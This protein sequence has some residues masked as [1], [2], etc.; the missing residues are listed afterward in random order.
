MAV[1]TKCAVATDSMK[2]KNCCS[3]CNKECDN[4]CKNAADKCGCL[5]QKLVLTEEQKKNRLKLYM[6]EYNRKRREADPEGVRARQREYKR[7]NK[8]RKKKCQG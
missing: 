6:K 7:Y 8:E 2:C 1:R 4:R 5:Q 3:F